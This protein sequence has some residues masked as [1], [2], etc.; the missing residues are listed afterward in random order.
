M[1]QTFQCLAPLLDKTLQLEQNPGA[2]KRIRVDPPPK[3]R[4]KHG[5]NQ[6]DHQPDVQTTLQLMA[7]LMLRLDRDMQVLSREHTF[8]LFFSCNEPTGALKLL[9]QKG[10]EWNQQAQTAT[11]PSKMMPLRQTLLHKCSSTR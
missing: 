11:S 5:P 8:L 7:R 10:T 3:G 6:E 9:L 1:L 4:G 2:T